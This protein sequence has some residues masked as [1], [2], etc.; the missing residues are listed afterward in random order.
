[1][2]KIIY[3]MGGL[4]NVLYQ[5]NFAYFVKEKGYEVEINTS[6]IEKNW[7]TKI[8]QWK[9]HR[10]TKEA[11]VYFI[12]NEFT[13]QN[14][15]Q[16]NILAGLLKN[17][18][19]NL[20]FKSKFFGHD[21]PQISEIENTKIFF[22]YFQKTNYLND[23]L[24]DYFNNNFLE[25]FSEEVKEKIKHPENVVIHFRVGDKLNDSRFDL[26]FNKLLKNYSFKKL[27]I[28]SD[29]NDPKK[30]NRFSSYNFEVISGANVLEDF[31]LIQLAQ[32]KILSRSSFS[33][34]AAELSNKNSTVIEH[35]PFY[36]H[37]DWQPFSNIKRHRIET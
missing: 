9:V 7:L 5:L 22:G 27:L 1:M 37:V 30:F 17:K 14:K 16:L 18:I 35:Y 31:K 25:H 20:I 13:L 10:G 6:L 15:P 8:A 34:W 32:N 23:K 24:K 26:D 4:G 3:L 21:F 29:N 36:A 2:K 11:M 28:I 33:W 12:G 19:F